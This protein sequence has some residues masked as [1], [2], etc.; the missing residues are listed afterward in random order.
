M[1]PTTALP[2]DGSV[3]DVVEL[4][5]RLPARMA[6]LL[7]VLVESEGDPRK[8]PM[9]DRDELI[10][11]LRVAG[12]SFQRI[13]MVM[14]MAV[15]HTY[16][17]VRKA[18]GVAMTGDI[19]EHRRELYI[20]LKLFIEEMRPLVH[21]V[22]GQPLDKDTGMMFLRACKALALLMGLEE[23][24]Q[25]LVAHDVSMGQD[26]PQ[27]AEFVADLVAWQ[28]KHGAISVEGNV[29]IPLPPGMTE[30]PAIAA[31]TN[32]HAHHGRL[33]HGMWSMVVEFPRED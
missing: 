17:I 10:I 15:S 28:K 13:A 11:R 3:L 21:G 23:P 12:A 19:I 26:N 14:D 8:M 4:A 16:R 6:E 18:T 7:S 5:E 2:A 20:D 30:R 32:G 27:A 9:A 33:G 31:S 1:M 24:K 25:R 29:S 22:S